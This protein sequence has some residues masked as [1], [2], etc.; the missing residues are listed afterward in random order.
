MEKSLILSLMEQ[1]SEDSA[2]RTFDND[3]LQLDEL[4]VDLDKPLCRISLEL[5]DI[6][7]FY[8]IYKYSTAFKAT[9]SLCHDYLFNIAINNECFV[10]R[11]DET[12]FIDGNELV[13]E[14][15]VFENFS[16]YDL[17]SVRYYEVKIIRCFFANFIIYF[18][19]YWFKIVYLFIANY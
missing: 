7:N 8:K 18:N 3:D 14:I 1:I 16:N 5:L 10:P 4:S 6:L 17:E 9:A 19:F 11:I 15:K 12:H 2:Y 13:K